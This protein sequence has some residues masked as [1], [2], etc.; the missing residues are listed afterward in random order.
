M[1]AAFPAAE[2][3]EAAVP[4]GRPARFAG[5]NPYAGKSLKGKL[6]SKSQETVK[7]FTM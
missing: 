5:E 7:K 4:L 6:L 2:A 3:G 1:A